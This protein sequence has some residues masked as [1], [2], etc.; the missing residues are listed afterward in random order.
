[1][2]P[3]IVLAPHPDDEVL[4][5]STILRRGPTTV[6][7]ITDGVPPWTD[8]AAWATLLGRRRA[9][10]AAAW[11]VL[12][13]D[14][15]GCVQLGFDDLRVW[16]AVPQLADALTDY[17]A[18]SDPA[19][20]H[21][22]AHQGGHPDHDATF[23][24]ALL[25]RRRTGDRHIWR[26]YGLYGYPSSERL[27]FGSLERGHYGDAS[28]VGDTTTELERKAAA[29][30]CFTSQLFPGS[31]VQRWLDA[32]AAEADAPLP[33][34]LPTRAAACFYDQELDFARY[35][36]TA[37]TVRVALDLALSDST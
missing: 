23:A 37:T 29:L 22:P 1:V 6:V 4:G 13:A 7:H 32:P 18:R 36:V 21:V 16:R 24:A 28:R 5:A 9:E 3:A 25:A 33:D 31:I 8:P 17:L 10:C 19:T 20:V 34:G 14:V 35:G 30:R 27:A 15:A 11:G 2:I 12:D 26:V